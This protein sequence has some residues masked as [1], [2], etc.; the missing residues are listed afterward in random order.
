M[1]PRPFSAD[2]VT[3][4]PGLRRSPEVRIS[5]GYGRDTLRRDKESQYDTHRT[6]SRRDDRGQARQTWLPTT[7]LGSCP[8]QTGRVCAP[9]RQIIQQTR[10]RTGTPVFPMRAPRGVELSAQCMPEVASGAQTAQ[11]PRWRQLQRALDVADRAL[12]ERGAAGQIGCVKPR[13][14]H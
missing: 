4:V 7:P 11:A 5:V 6:Q 13:H 10:Q 12:S 9:E 8:R 14:V 3:G 1:P 2:L